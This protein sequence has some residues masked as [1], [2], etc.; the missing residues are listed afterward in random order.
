ML[1]C[2]R[3]LEYQLVWLL[4]G[5]IQAKILSSTW[6]DCYCQIQWLRLKVLL[7]WYHIREERI[8]LLQ[9]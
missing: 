4:C 6:D 8:G 2:R 9:H 7:R 1:F 3:A 5:V